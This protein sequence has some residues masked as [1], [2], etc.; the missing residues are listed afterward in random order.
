MKVLN[1]YPG[2]HHYWDQ[3]VKT[4]HYC[5]N[6]GAQSVWEEQSAGDYYTGAEFICVACKSSWTMQG[7]SI[8]KEENMLGKVEQ[9]R[10]GVTKEPSTNRGG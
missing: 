5:P 1:E 3:F 10:S 6:C 7:P 4:N 2:S 8:S 9:L